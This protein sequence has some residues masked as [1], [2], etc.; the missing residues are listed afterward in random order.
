MRHI[1][2]GKDNLFHFKFL[3]KLEQ[4]NLGIDRYAFRIHLP[5]QLAGIR[6]PLDIG[7]LGRSECHHFIVR[8][9][10][11]EDVEV[12]EVAPSGAHDESSN[13]GHK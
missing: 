4:V 2:I 12:V 1:R 13:R 8:V 3:D 6:A 5:S 9:I 10:A 7:D 11:E